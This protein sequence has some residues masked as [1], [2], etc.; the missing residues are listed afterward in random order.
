MVDENEL[1]TPIDSLTLECPAKLNLALSVGAARDSDG[2]HPISTWMATI[3]LCDELTLERR[4]EKSITLIGRAWHDEAPVRSDLDWPLEKD[5]VARAHTAMERAAGMPLKVKATLRK[6]IP[7]GGGLGGGSS[8]AAATLVG[9]NR[10]FDLRFST[11]ELENIAFTLGSDVAFFV[12]GGS[13]IVE[14]M[15]DTIER[16]AD[17]PVFHGVLVIPEFGCP[18]GAV[19]RTFD[20]LGSRGSGCAGA[21]VEPDRVRQLIHA[22]RSARSIP[23]ETLWND[24]ALAACDVAPRMAGIQEELADLAGT[25][26]HVTGS[27]SCLFALCGDSIT[28]RALAAH[29]SRT[30]DTPAVALQSRPN[31]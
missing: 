26:A 6:R 8:N 14:G 3:D 13:A 20:R 10:L 23:S 22:A 7:V 2:M 19:Y 30:L 24:L 15:G 16:V 29:A 21:V 17:T 12:R 1:A 25:P 11:E 4:D 18:T 5:L 31:G 9:L 28:A 27:G